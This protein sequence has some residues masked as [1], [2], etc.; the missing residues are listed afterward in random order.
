MHFGR[1]KQAMT[2]GIFEDLALEIKTQGHC[3]KALDLAQNSP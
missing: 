1:M 3:Y 2:L